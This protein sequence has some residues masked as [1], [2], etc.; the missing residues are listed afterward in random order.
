MA[1]CA[2]CD[3]DHGP[4]LDHMSEDQ[5]R[6]RIHVQD[7]ER[8]QLE[9]KIKALRSFAHICS[10]EQYESTTSASEKVKDHAH[11]ARKVLEE[12]K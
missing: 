7:R 4:C 1:S 6:Q 2:W 3:P 12:T 9:D 5:L 10:L 8:I 11:R